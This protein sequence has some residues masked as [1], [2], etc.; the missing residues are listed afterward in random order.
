M[1]VLQ[2]SNP[3]LT[4]DHFRSAYGHMMGSE[5]ATVNGVIHKTFVLVGLAVGA[6]ALGY[7]V[8][9]TIPAA[10]WISSL[11]ALVVTMGVYF[12]LRSKPER[13]K[14]LGPIYALA[15]GFF[16]GALTAVF[17]SMLAAS[18]IAV[19]GGLALQAFIV[20]AS[21]M[22]AM[23]LL[24]RAGIIKPTARFQS[25]LS[26]VTL[27]ITITYL[28]SFALSFFGISMPLIGLSGAMAGG[29][30]AWIGLGLNVVILGVA[31][32]WL[33][34]DFGLVEDTVRSGAPKDMEWYCGFALTVSLA[35][36]YYEA[37]KVCFRL[38]L[39]LSNRD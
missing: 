2:S 18:K 3:V 9:Q 31:S 13:A 12:G 24:Y 4:D 29:Q 6:G 33:V 27:G 11:V 1:T 25:V 28:I 7:S 36:V 21:V 19:P 23:L 20:T 5:T 37:L 39:L 32:L 14:I 26:T 30:A 15:E 10:A 34:I 8:G 38:A 16:L 35:W 22:G 17:E